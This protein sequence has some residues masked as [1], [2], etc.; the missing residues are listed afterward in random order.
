MG[1][2]DEIYDLYKKILSDKGCYKDSFRDSDY[3]I[4]LIPCWAEILVPLERSVCRVVQVREEI[5]A[6]GSDMVFVRC[7][8]GTLMPWENQSF[9]EVKEEYIPQ[10]ET[11]FS[12]V[13]EWDDNEEGRA[14]GYNYPDN[15]ENVVGFIIPSPHGDDYVSPTKAIKTAI[16]KKLDNIVNQKQTQN[17]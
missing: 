11:I 10:L 14:L 2:K 5:G 3:G 4:Y 17:R 8:D 16:F 12:E 1:K 7:S 6:F 9:F 15:K 13:N